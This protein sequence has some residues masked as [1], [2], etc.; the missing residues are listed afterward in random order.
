MKTIR[1]QEDKRRSAAIN[2]LYGSK[3][4]NISKV[5]S[6]FPHKITVKFISKLITEISVCV[7]KVPIITSV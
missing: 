4:I 5:R 1:K 6:S 7:M 3:N 2:Q